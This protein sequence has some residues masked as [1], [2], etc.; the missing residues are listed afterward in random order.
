MTGTRQSFPPYATVDQFDG[1]P[2]WLRNELL[3]AHATI[4]QLLR[5]IEHEQERYAEMAR[6][7]KLTVDNL[8]EVTRQNTELERERD[9][10]RAR[11]DSALVI[12]L[13]DG[14]FALTADEIGA[15][16]RAIARLHHPDRG[17]DARR[18]QVWNAAL[19]ALE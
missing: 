15:M 19:D 10:Y 8:V 4:H 12:Q 16:R 2:E 5:Q 18:M 9:A 13:G 3:E 1:D 11:A 6:A 14:P 7:Y 17:G